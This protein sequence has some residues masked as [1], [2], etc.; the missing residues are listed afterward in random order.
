MRVCV[1]GAGAIGGL[2]GTRLA[3]AGVETSALARGVTLAALRAHGW[4]RIRR[5][6]D[7]RPGPGLG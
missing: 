7:R 1:L 3:A 5:P 4:R 6:P 2:I